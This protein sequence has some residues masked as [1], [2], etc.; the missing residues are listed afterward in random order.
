MATRVETEE[1]FY[2]VWPFAEPLIASAL[3]DN[4]NIARIVKGLFDRT[5]TLFVNEDTAC[6]VAPTEWRG[7][8]YCLIDVFSGNLD[9]IDTPEYAELT[10]YA[11]DNNC[12]GFLLN[13]RRGWERALKP[14]GYEFDAVVLTKEF[15]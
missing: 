1:Q 5:H 2:E 3:S 6:V 14:Y 7:K 10:D 15:E 9:H 12:I 4:D 8:R 13:G 11:L